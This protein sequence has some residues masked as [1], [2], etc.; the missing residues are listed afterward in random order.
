[1]DSHIGIAMPYGLM[2]EASVRPSGKLDEAS[3]ASPSGRVLRAAT[4]LLGQYPTL[5]HMALKTM[6]TLW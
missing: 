4:G 3:P 2:D 6:G 5:S 1:M